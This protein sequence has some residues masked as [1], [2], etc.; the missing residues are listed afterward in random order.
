MAPIPSEQRAAIWKAATL[1]IGTAPQRSSSYPLANSHIPLYSLFLPSPHLFFSQYLI[2]RA[3]F[4]HTYHHCQPAPPPFSHFSLCDAN[5]FGLN[6]AVHT[7]V[8]TIAG[9]NTRAASIQYKQA[10]EEC[11][12][13]DFPSKGPAAFCGDI[14][15]ISAGLH[16]IG[17]QPPPGISLDGTGGGGGGGGG[18]SGGA[19]PAVAGGGGAMTMQ[20][21]RLYRVLQRMAWIHTSS[22]VPLPLYMPWL[23]PLVAVLLRWLPEVSA[24]CAHLCACPRSSRA[25]AHQEDN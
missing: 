5:W 14:S 10:G 16:S 24:V 13:H 20:D 8:H 17:P 19:G 21:P 7:C 15:M 1:G 4:S 25:R 9:T 2:V 6:D 3:L 18:G 12:A 22:G 11:E 23:P